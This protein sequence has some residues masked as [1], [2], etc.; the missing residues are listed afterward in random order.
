MFR[1]LLKHTE[2]TML[3]GF[4][5]ALRF[6]RVVHGPI[7]HRHKLGASSKRIHRAAFNEGFEHPLVQQP[8]INFFAELV[9]GFESAEFLAGGNNGFNRIVSN[10]LYRC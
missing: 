4:R 5:I 7:K 8:E 9:N 2:Q 3:P 1:I 6:L 10:V